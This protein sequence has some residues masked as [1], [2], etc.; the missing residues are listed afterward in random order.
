MELLAEVIKK[1]GR[2]RVLKTWAGEQGGRNV[3]S[4]FT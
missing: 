1:W 2:A 3:G 4:H